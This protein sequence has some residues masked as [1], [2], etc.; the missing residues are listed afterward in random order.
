MIKKYGS[1]AQVINE[2]GDQRKPHSTCQV[3]G[4]EDVNTYPLLALY[5]CAV[6][7][8]VKTGGQD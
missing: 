7:I 4:R 6:C 5:A 3:C 1:M 2:L 8:V